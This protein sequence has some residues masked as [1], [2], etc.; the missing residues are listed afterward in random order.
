MMIAKVEDT[1]KEILARLKS[2]QPFAYNRVGDGA[3]MLINGWKGDASDHYYS[4][5]LRDLL[6][7]ALQLDDPRFMMGLHCGFEVEPFMTPQSFKPHGN[8]LELEEIYKGV[9][10]DWGERTLWSAVAFQAGIIHYPAVTKEIVELIAAKKVAVVAGSHL[11]GVEKF[12]GP[13]AVFIEAPVTNAFDVIE[14]LTT[15]VY[16]VQP[17]IVV[18]GCGMAGVLL[19][20]FLF[21]D[22]CNITTLN[23]GSFMDALMGQNTRGWIGENLDAINSFV[24]LCTFPSTPQDVK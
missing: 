14:D 2:G 12:F 24:Q 9:V 16:E 18:T 19:Q 20:Y 10:T 6:K 15:K 5:K 13:G 22:N 8:D 11:K 1:L 3:L 4:P 21:I 7:L 17:D 23:L